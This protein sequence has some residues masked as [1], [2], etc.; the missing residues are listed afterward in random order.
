[1]KGEEANTVISFIYF[2]VV[3]TTKILLYLE[4]KKGRD[5]LQSD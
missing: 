4:L 3:T 5:Y 2:K 1:M